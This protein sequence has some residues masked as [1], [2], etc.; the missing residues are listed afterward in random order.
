MD[1]TEKWLTFTPTSG[2]GAS[3]FSWILS[4]ELDCL[5]RYLS[6]SMKANQAMRK[7]A[8]SATLSTPS[9]AASGATTVWANG[10]AGPPYFLTDY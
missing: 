2:V 3:T 7:M 10:P 5:G 9:V 6:S 4:K 1:V 8:A